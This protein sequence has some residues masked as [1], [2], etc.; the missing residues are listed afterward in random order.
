MAWKLPNELRVFYVEIGEA[1]AHGELANTLCGLVFDLC[2]FLLERIELSEL[3]S[4]LC[5]QR[6][7]RHVSLHFIDSVSPA[8]RAPSILTGL[9]LMLAKVGRERTAF[10]ECG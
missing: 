1:S 5:G 10:D 9:S 2:K 7:P 6:F 3:F 8:A 4:P